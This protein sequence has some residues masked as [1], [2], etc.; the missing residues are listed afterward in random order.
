MPKK[1][2]KEKEKDNK[3]VK[4]NIITKVDEVI[5]IGPNAWSNSEVRV[6]KDDSKIIVG[7]LNKI[8]EDNF[9]KIVQDTKNLN[10]KTKNIVDL[11]FTKSVHNTHHSAIYAEYCKRLELDSIVNEMSFEQFNLKKNKNLCK[12]IGSLYKIDVI[13][14]ELINQFIKIL[15]DN[16]NENNLELL[17]E[18]LKASK[19][20]EFSEI[21]QKLDL[22]KTKF[23]TRMKFAIMDVIDLLT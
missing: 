5:K 10:Y 13:K 19:S 11:I 14:V 15:T 16:L 9:E 2:I 18:I 1:Q 3:W 17:L 6:N 20:N 12:F 8:S 23:S 4:N 22:I 7:L 21:I